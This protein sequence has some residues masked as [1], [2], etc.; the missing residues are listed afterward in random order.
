MSTTRTS[1]T[2]N[3]YNPSGM[4]VYNSFQNPVQQGWQQYSQNPL[5]SSWFNQEVNQSNQMN[6]NIGNTMNQVNTLNSAQTPMDNS[7]AVMNA[8]KARNQRAMQSRQSQGFNALLMNANNVRQTALG[9]MQGY[10]PLQISQTSKQS[11]G[12]LGTWATPLIQ[13][14]LENSGGGGGGMA[15]MMGG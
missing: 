8:M 7:P 5:T 14:V 9:Q 2:T 4:G 15:A 3:S 11:T 10:Q 12:G 13:A 1:T 6:T